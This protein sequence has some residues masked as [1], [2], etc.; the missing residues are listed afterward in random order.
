MAS[1]LLRSAGAAAG[2]AL[3]PGIGGALLGTLGRS[4]GVVIDGQLGLGTQVTGPRLENLSVQD[5]RYGAAIPTVY[6]RARVAGNV[7]WS[8]DLIEAQHDSSFSGG[9]G[10]LS[11]SSTTTTTYTYSVHCAIGIALGPI[12]GLTTI[13]ADSTVIYQNGIWTTGLVD[14]ASIYTGSSTQP[15]DPFMQSMLGSANVPAYRGLAYIVLENLQLGNFGNR[16]PNLTFEILPVTSSTATPRKSA[17]C[18]SA[19]LRRSAALLPSKRS[20]SIFQATRRLNSRGWRAPVSA[21]GR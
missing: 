17:R 14:S 21:A 9:K 6:G 1:I 13:W 19:G 18:C 10:A 11:G 4:I 7:I 16:L 3:L 15:A 5:S 12:A 2:N 20:R 8:S